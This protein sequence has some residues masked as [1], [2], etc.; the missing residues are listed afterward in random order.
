MSGIIVLGTFMV[1][2]FLSVPILSSIIIAA[3]TGVIAL[4]FSDRLGIVSQQML[5]GINSP[6]LLSVPFF[7]LAG[8]LL[9]GLELTDRIFRFANNIVG[10]IRGGLAQVNI[11]ASLLFAGISG[12]AVADCAAL[13]TVEV[14][15]MRERG[16]PVPF[17]AGVTAASSIIG[18]IF[19]PSIPLL[20]FAF[21]ANA[22]VGRLFLAGVV[23]AI[24][25]L[26]MLM[27]Y[28][29]I[30]AAKR[31]FPKEKRAPLREIM[32]SAVD[33]LL[34]LMAPAIILVA[35]LT[36][37]TTASEAG[38]LACV[39][40]M[41]LG[42]WYRT[43][44]WKVLAKAFR[45]TAM[46]S[47]I[48]LLMIGFSS[49]VGWIL[50]FDMVPQRPAD[51]VLGSIDAKWQFLL[52][53]LLFLILLGCVFDATAALI[54]LV[55]IM[56]PLVDGFGIDRVHYGIITVLTLMV[57]ILTPPIG[58]ALYIMMDVAK[59]PFEAVARATLPFLIPIMLAVLLITFV[60]EISLFLPNLVY[61]AP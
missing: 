35:M 36:G 3:A 18:P 58:I 33:G 45:E 24:V 15:A 9:N 28:V 40:A 50:A 13:G 60:P 31:N 38:V 56:L 11:L 43:L 23:P 19:P 16:Y 51:F 32:A 5:D 46:L 12:A 59:L 4:G 6:A 53:Y 48:A 20:L 22:S 34:T 25:L 21:V 29:H 10:H 42:V 7:I 17:A 61:G 30:I 55:P 52:I 49:C 14:K 27:G 2:A 54:I 39:Y 57:G 8:N 26:I 44:T 47:T 1:L 37:F 41:A